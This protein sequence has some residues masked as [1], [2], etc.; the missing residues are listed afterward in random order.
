MAEVKPPKK[1]D[2]LNYPEAIEGPETPPYKYIPAT[3]P[4]LSGL[5]LTLAAAAIVNLPPLATFFYN[6]GGFNCLSKVP[7]LIKYSPRY[8]PTVIPIQ[9]SPTS[10]EQLIAASNSAYLDGGERGGSPY[11]TFADFHA[12][13]RAGK[14]TPSRVAE[15]VLDLIERDERFRGA[16][17]SVRKE[18]VLRAARE[19]T[20]RWSVGKSRGVLDGVPVAVKGRRVHSIILLVKKNKSFIRR[21]SPSLPDCI[22]H[23]NLCSHSLKLH[24]HIPLLYMENRS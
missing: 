19:A 9:T 18:D 3:N 10:P 17:V 8:D 16:F 21:F 1:K 11:T 24:Y 15:T 23:C 20:E 4:V 22:D 13:F 7:D 12:S 5:P 14:T 6:N 2:F